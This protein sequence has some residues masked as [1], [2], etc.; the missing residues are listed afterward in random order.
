[1][2]C[3]QKLFGAECYGIDPSAKAVEYGR[4]HHP[5]INLSCGSADN[6]TFPKDR[7]D[8]VIFGFC[9]YL[10]DPQ[11]YFRI[12]QE[13]DRVLRDKGFLII[14]DF[15]SPVPMRGTYSHLP[16]IFSHKL[17]WAS[18]FTWNPAYRLISRSYLEPAQKSMAASDAY[19]FHPQEQMALDV[20]RKDT[21]KAFIS[22]PYGAPV[23][24]L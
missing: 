19:S 1:L 8:L 16:G 12:A 11:D 18:M 13:T 15:T 21:D 7:F 4:T 20:L 24:A 10:C 6:L 17:D 22:N 2:N 5:K 23:A 14:K 9:L 3:I